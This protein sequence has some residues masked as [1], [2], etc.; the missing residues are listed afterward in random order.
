MTP[1][2][3]SKASQYGIAIASL[4]LVTGGMLNCDCPGWFVCAGIAAMFPAALGPR[5]SRVAGVCLCLASF[6]FAVVQF[7][8]ERARDVRIRQAL[9]RA[10]GASQLP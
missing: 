10:R 7:D 1:A 2:A 8:N 3:K 9:E 5:V 4:G 6:A